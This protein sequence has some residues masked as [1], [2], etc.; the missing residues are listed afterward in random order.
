[1]LRPL[2][3]RDHVPL[4][5]DDHDRVGERI[6]D[7]G[8]HLALLVESA[9]REAEFLDSGHARQNRS[10]ESGS[11]NESGQ[12]YVVDRSLE[13]SDAA[14]RVTEPSTSIGRGPP[15]HLTSLE[16]HFLELGFRENSWRAPELWLRK[17]DRRPLSER[18]SR[19]RRYPVAAYRVKRKR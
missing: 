10:G 2:V 14:G 9:G 4:G 7:R 1:M 16:L 15:S 11:V 5:V 3:L 18:D 12:S 17:W 6:H 13:K 19:K 8:Q